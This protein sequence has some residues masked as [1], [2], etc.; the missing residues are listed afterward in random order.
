MDKDCHRARA[1]FIDKSVDVREEFSFAHP[2]QI[3]KMVQMLCT[4]AYGSMLWNLRSN[5]T[6]QYFKCWNTCVK[7]VYGVPR[8]T[9]TYLVEGYFAQSYASLRN[10]V[11]SRYPG[12]YRNL[13]RSP[14]KEVRMLAKMVSNDPRSPTCTNLRYMRE[15]TSLEQAESFSSWRIR[16]ALPVQNVPDRETWRL[17]LLH[18]LMEVRSENSRNVK[19]T[20]RICAMIDSL[21][22][23]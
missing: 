10:Q 9:F 15:I 14:S 21:C 1:K 18:S 11:L 19:D 12:F 4:D 3:L 5:P 8:S 13:L 6:E 17:G 23:T 2:D 20:K 7:L 22:S 16:E